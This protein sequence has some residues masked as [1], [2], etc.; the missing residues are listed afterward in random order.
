MQL[1]FTPL[2]LQRFTRDFITTTAGLLVAGLGDM[3]QRHMII[4]ARVRSGRVS[5][6]EVRPQQEQRSRVFFVYKHFTF[7]QLV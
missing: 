2:Q 4:I 3:F 6:V 5:S 1:E 7:L